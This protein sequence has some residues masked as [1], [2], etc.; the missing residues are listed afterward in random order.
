MLVMLRSVRNTS[1][2]TVATTTSTRI[3]MAK[4]TLAGSNVGRRRSRSPTDVRLA[5][6]IGSGRTPVGGNTGRVGEQRLHGRLG[7][8]ELGDETPAAHHQHAVA[9]AEHLGHVRR[10][11]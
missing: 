9:H 6:V 10:D 5:S 3:A 8:V 11:Q 2:A 1:V 7:T 4:P